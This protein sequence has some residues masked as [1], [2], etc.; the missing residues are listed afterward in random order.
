MYLTPDDFPLHQ[1]SYSNLTQEELAVSV[2]I[3]KFSASARTGSPDCRTV[4]PRVGKGGLIMVNFPPPFNKKIRLL[5]ACWR[6]Q[7]SGDLGR[8]AMLA[9]V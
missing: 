4:V 6:L 2:N 9:V 3:D 1:A 5:S 8:R 7:P